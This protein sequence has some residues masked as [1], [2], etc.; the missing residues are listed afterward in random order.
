MANILI[1]TGLAVLMHYIALVDF[2]LLLSFDSFVKFGSEW[3]RW[4]V[5]EWAA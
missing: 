3:E 2:S 4:K 1:F 5:G